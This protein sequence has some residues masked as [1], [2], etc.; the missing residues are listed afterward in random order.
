[1]P[2]DP[3]HAEEYEL[4]TLSGAR[5]DGSLSDEDDRSPR[6]DRDRLSEDAS[7]RKSGEGVDADEVPLLGEG[8]EVVGKGTKVEE[9]IARVGI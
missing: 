3:N 5:S 4:P 2:V 7:G 6:H 1:M 8:A 9:L